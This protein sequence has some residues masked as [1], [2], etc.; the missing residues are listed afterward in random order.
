MRT[1]QNKYTTMSFIMTTIY[2]TTTTMKTSQSLEATS[3]S[4]T[5]DYQTQGETTSKK[6]NNANNKTNP[7]THTRN[8][9]NNNN[10][11][12]NNNDNN[13]H[14]DDNKRQQRH[15]NNNKIRRMQF[16][17][18]IK[19]TNIK[20]SINQTPNKSINRLIKQELVTNKSVTNQS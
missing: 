9:N 15:N 7:H 20:S 19:I 2:W 5:I 12:S 16:E 18:I 14:D 3:K 10:N 1:H 6:D 13:N 8:N 17:I 11:N 4:H